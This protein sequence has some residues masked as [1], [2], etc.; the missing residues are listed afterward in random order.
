MPDAVIIVK[1]F[2]ENFLDKNKNPFFAFTDLLKVFDRVPSKML[3]WAMHVVGVPGWIVIIVQAT[4]NG[5]KSKVI[6]NGSYIDEFEV[7]V[8]VHQCLVLG[9]LLFVV[10]LEA[11]S[12]EF[13]TSCPCELL[14]ADDLV[15]LAE[16]LN[17]LME[18]LKLWKDNME[19]KGL[20]VNM[21]KTKVILGHICQA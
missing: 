18:K 3:W 1:Q 8:G 5:A 19:S 2:Q 13:R 15:L 12:R 14:Y 17:L 6:V 16:T 4:Y 11:L 9:Q 21:G 20:C 7:K 10:V